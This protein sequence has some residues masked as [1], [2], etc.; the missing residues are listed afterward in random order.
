MNT[1][2]LLIW[3]TGEYEVL[4]YER[5]KEETDIESNAGNKENG[6]LTQSNDPKS[7][8]AQLQESFRKVSVEFTEQ[9]K[10]AWL[11]HSEG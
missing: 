9:R 1:G 7:Q 3:E 11:M 4:P 5:L 10:K 8:P 6:V 2:S